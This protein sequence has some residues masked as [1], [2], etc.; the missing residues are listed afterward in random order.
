MQQVK[1]RSLKSYLRELCLPEL[2]NAWPYFSIQDIRQS[3]KKHKVPYAERTLVRYLHKLVA[4]GE[5]YHAG[6]GWYSR[7]ETPFVLDVSAIQG[8]AEELEHA[9]PL[10]DFS[11]WST[12]QVQGAMH[13]LLGGFVSFVMVE[14]DA[15]ETLWE[16]LDD[17]GW[18]AQLNPRGQEAERFR[19]RERTVVIRKASS[20]SRPPERLAS[21]ERLLVELYFE[22]RDLALMSEEDYHAMI[23]NLAGTRRIRISLLLSYAAERKLEISDLLGADNQ[24]IPPIHNRRN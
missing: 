18:D 10:V 24:L 4:A 11:L 2:L 23:G 7:I 13:H 3:L 16:H 9:F 22:R 12:A 21:I 1:P 20:K 15:M 19:A 14:A 6:R 5:L 8:L 17:L